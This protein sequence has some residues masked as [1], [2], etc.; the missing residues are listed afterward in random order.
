MTGLVYIY[1][2]EEI[3]CFAQGL[4]QIAWSTSDTSAK[5]K[6]IITYENR[7]LIFIY[8]A[9]YFFINLTFLFVPGIIKDFFPFDLLIEMSLI[10]K[11]IGY[12]GGAFYLNSS[13]FIA[14]NNVFISIS[15]ALS[16]KYQVVMF[17]KTLFDF[18][19]KCSK[20][21]IHYRNYPTYQTY[22]KLQLVSLVKRH[23]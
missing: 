7:V 11:C 4:T 22:V 17:N 6:G 8:Y 16:L 1:T 21:P 23:A 5:I 20:K 2:V 9:G 3:K 19:I 12:V 14:I 18:M 10:Y 13:T 15:S